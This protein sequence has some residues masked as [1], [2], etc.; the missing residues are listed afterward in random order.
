MSK[1]W[2]A[3]GFPG[4]FVCPARAA[5]R[6]KATNVSHEL[7]YAKPKS[8]VAP[9]ATAELLKLAMP[10]IGLTVSRMAMG[11][12][13]FVMVSRLGTDAQAAISPATIFVFALACL[14]MGAAQSATLSANI[15]SYGHIYHHPR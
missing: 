9:S 7:E 1:P 13:D 10:I 5:G 14:G 11:F 2:Q 15:S 6:V 3:Y 4:F 8:L 12:I